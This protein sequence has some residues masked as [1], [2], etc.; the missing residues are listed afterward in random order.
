MQGYT[1]FSIPV[2]ILYRPNDAKVKNLKTKNYLGQARL[3]AAV[4]RAAN[5]TFDR[6]TVAEIIHPEDR[7]ISRDAILA[8]AE[9][10]A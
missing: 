3:V 5:F 6:I 7:H 9:G 10:R 8:G 1:V 2:G 4:N